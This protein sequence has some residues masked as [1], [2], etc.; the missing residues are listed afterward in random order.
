MKTLKENY[1]KNVEI[2]K[3]NLKRGMGFE[4][5]KRN[6]DNMERSFINA[7]VYD[8]D[9]KD[10]INEMRK[11]LIEKFTNLEINLIK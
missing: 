9:E 6:I 5:A 8:N 2:L 10:F 4:V 1:K 11:V 7:K 3:E